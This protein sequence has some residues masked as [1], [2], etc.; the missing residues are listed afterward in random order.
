VPAD[1][2]AAIQALSRLQLHLLLLLAAIE[3]TTSA[4]ADAVRVLRRQVM[5]LLLFAVGM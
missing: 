1:T 5:L 3:A 2:F 4:V